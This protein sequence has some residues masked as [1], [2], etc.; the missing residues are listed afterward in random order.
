MRPID[1]SDG[2]RTTRNACCLKMVLAKCRVPQFVASAAALT[3]DA[4]EVS[5]FRPI[6]HAHSFGNQ[7]HGMKAADPEVVADVSACAITLP[8]EPRSDNAVDT[9][10]LGADRHSWR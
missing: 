4:S 5:W 10:G 9:R 2:S 8:V 6:S 1:V 7:T 3:L